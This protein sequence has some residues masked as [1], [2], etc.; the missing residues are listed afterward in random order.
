MRGLWIGIALS[1]SV[2]QVS[3]AADGPKRVASCLD[4]RFAEG[5][6]PF[7][8]VRL[9]AS[10]TTY[11]IAAD[12]SCLDADPAACKNRV[13]LEADRQWI[14]GA[15]AR[16][17]ACVTDGTVFGWTPVAELEFAP[18]PATEAKDW[19]GAWDRQHGS[20]SFRVSF[21]NDKK[22]LHVTGN[23]EWQ[24]GPD[25]TPHL[26]DLDSDGE[27]VANELRLGEPK[28]LDYEYNDAHQECWQCVARLM[29][30]NGRVFV[31]DNHWCGGMNVNF[32]GIYDR[33]EAP[34]VR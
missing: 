9:S 15:R 25:A 6:E 2:L 3:P 24:A 32:D 1:T 16:D 34:R 13:P 4:E 33:A 8:R 31:K 26:G 10:K 23:A 27:L 22:T 21:A 5:V 17:W 20:A 19:L 7:S 28:C 14:A 18:V 30:I 29:L 12:D 11:R